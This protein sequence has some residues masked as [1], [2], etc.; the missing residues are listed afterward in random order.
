MSGIAVGYAHFYPDVRA[1]DAVQPMNDGQA[2][3]SDPKSK[4]GLGEPT[5][6]PYV[7]RT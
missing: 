2:G 3:D 4:L 1:L 7:I 5:E 6:N